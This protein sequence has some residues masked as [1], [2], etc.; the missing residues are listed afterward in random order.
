MSGENRF[1][2]NIHSPLTPQT[3]KKKSRRSKSLVR[4]KT[5]AYPVVVSI[6]S[7]SKAWWLFT[8]KV[9]KP[10][11]NFPQLFENNYRESHLPRHGNLLCYLSNLLDDGYFYSNVA[12]DQPGTYFL[13]K[14]S[15]ENQK[16]K[17]ILISFT[18]NVGTQNT[19]TKFQRSFF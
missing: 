1:H 15:S 11:F 4:N 16:N 19:K 13:L 7:Q 18:L 3:K 10:R 6:A 9:L 5:L 12:P 2:S 8:R 17:N 14:L